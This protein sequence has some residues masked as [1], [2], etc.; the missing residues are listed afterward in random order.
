MRFFK[1]FFCG[2]TGIPLKFKA[3]IHLNLRAGSTFPV[4]VCTVSPGLWVNISRHSIGLADAT[5]LTRLDFMLYI[6]ADL[7]LPKGQ[8]CVCRNNFIN[9]GIKYR[10][11][12]L[13]VPILDMKINRLWLTIS[14]NPVSTQK[15]GSQAAKI[16]GLEFKSSNYNSFIKER[17]NDELR[18][19]GST[20]SSVRFIKGIGDQFKN[21][22]KNH[23]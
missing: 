16:W 11:L 15:F 6:G 12:N 19:A 20:T 23:V 8:R 9:W 5:R 4:P 13:N 21:Y 17:K 7:L 14:N 3:V 10:S 2:H 1:M 18:F 22:K